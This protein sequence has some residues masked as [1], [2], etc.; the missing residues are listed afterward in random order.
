MD[1]ALLLYSGGLDT[2]V[3]IKW[4]QE[5]L[6]MDVATLTL[7]VGN[8]DLVAIEEKARMLGAD[9]VFVHDAKDEFAEKFIAK[10]IMANGSYEGYPLST[11]LARPL[12]AEKAVKY[13]QKIGAKYIVH[14]STGRGNDQVRFEVSIR[15]LDPSMQVLVPVRE[16]NMMRKDEVEYAKTHGIPVKLDGKYSIDENIW[17]R[18]V[19]GP[20]LEDIGKAYLRMSM[21]GLCL[22]GR[23]MRN[24]H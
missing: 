10:S 17:G 13:A 15:A 21:N 3:M 1:K 4:I 14:G 24:I 7:N 12:M 22:H 23:L 18:S 2:S 20:D 11:A 19:E 8:S 9:P 6:S 5:N 16:W